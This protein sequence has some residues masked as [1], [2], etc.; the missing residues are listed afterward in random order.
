MT[1]DLLKS[2]ALRNQDIVF[3]VGD[4]TIVHICSKLCTQL[5]D[6]WHPIGTYFYDFNAIAGAAT[7]DLT[8]A[9]STT[10]SN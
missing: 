3:P 8:R 6:S 4:L 7:A 9:K 5:L 2:H 1:L 10:V